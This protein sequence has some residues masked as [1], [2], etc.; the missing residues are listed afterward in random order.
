MK[1]NSDSSSEIPCFRCLFW[2]KREKHIHCNPNKCE[3]LTEWLLNQVKK[4][5]KKIERLK[6]TVKR[7]EV[8]EGVGAA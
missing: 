7:L 6:Q 8:L 5:N 2:D 1:A 4:Y 3:E